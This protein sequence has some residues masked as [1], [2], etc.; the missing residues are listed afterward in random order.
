MLTRRTRY[1][2]AAALGSV[3]L[4][5]WAC[6]LAPG[7]SVGNS[8]A[9]P[10]T[11]PTIRLADA[12]PL[13]KLLTEDWQAN[14]TDKLDA[15]QVN[16]ALY[17][18]E[19][20]AY[21]DPDADTSTDAPDDA[22]PILAIK[23]DESWKAI[24]LVSVSLRQ[25]GWKYVAAGPAP[26][27]VWGALDTVAGDSR[28]RFVLAHSTDGGASFTL[29]PF[30]KPCKLAQF[31]DFAMSRDGHGR[32][33]VSLDTDCGPHQAGLY[34]YQTSNDGKTWSP[35]TFEPDV[36]LRS[37]PVPD[38]EQPDAPEP[39]HKTSVPQLRKMTPRRVHLW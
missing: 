13:V 25:A 4:P 30:T 22:I 27:E 8:P 35:P 26:G 3:A 10:T 31:F 7:R 29:T 39:G 11:G 17:F 21:T 18:G 9:A 2:L 5:L 6:T 14:L 28:P 32:A 19:L 38:D 23:T 37:D 24:P 1:R 34:H 15:P 16:Q 20:D 36:M 12:V 33:T